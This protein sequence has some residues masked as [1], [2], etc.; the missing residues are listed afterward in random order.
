M[1]KGQKRSSKEPRK[2]KQPTSKPPASGHSQ[3][4]GMFK[5]S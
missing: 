3:M 1:A 2:P 5:K 4:A